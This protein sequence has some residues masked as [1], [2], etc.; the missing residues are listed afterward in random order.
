MIDD[1]ITKDTLE[2]YR[3]FTSRAEHRLI[4]RTSNTC[5]RLL[6]TSR[7]FGLHEKRH[8]EYLASIIDSKNKTLKSLSA[9]IKPGELKTT[10][11]LSQPTPASSVLKESG[12]FYL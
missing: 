5:E 2:P 9:S 3:M 10:P 4:L 11:P 6:S 8:L 12:G 1:L 7:E